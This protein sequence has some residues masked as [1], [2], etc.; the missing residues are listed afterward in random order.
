MEHLTNYEGRDMYLIKN[1]LSPLSNMYMT[2]LSK[3]GV[4][5]NSAEH[6]YQFEKARKHVCCS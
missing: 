2:P 1:G 5:F 6:L 3:H 4:S